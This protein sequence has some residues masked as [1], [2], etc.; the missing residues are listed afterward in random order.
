M[1]DL[2][3]LL[4]DGGGKTVGDLIASGHIF[5]IGIELFVDLDGGGPGELVDGKLVEDDILIATFTDGGGGFTLA[6]DVLV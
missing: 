6:T 2:T 4:L 3:A 5:G 1:I